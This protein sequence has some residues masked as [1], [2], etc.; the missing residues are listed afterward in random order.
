MTDLS[1]LVGYFTQNPFKERRTNYAQ[2]SYIAVFFI[3]VQLPAPFFGP[4]FKQL[5]LRAPKELDSKLGVYRN[6]QD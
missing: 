4:G 2:H 3:K 6:L 5:Y 1:T